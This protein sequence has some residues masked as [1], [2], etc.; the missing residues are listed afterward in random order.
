LHRV[1][2]AFTDVSE[3]LSAHVV[4]ALVMVMRAVMMWAVSTPETSVK[5]YES[6][7]RNI[8][9]DIFTLAAVGT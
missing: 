5:F 2:Y 9:E 1:S 7:R 6:A 8:A 4:I 3:V